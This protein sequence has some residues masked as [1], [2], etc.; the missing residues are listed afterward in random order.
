M[1]FFYLVVKRCKFWIPDKVPC[2]SDTPCHNS[3][4]LWPIQ[5][6]ECN[7]TTS[8]NPLCHNK[9]Q[10]LGS[11]NRLE[12]WSGNPRQQHTQ[13]FNPEKCDGGALKVEELS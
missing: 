8:N 5:D 11:S 2:D 10:P 1:I 12:T 3:R 7:S 6:S 13:P 4:M 9:N